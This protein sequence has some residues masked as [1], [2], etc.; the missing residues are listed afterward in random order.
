MKTKSDFPESGRYEH[1]KKKD[2][3][4]NLF[5]RVY[6]KFHALPIQTGRLNLNENEIIC[7][8]HKHNYNNKINM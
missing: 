4:M 7:I 6:H 3:E 5:M 1:K 2:R 8:K